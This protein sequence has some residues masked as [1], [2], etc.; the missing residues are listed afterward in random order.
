MDANETRIRFHAKQTAA[1]VRL[2]RDYG[3][4]RRNPAAAGRIGVL[5]GV[6][7]VDSSGRSGPSGLQWAGSWS[8]N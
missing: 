3:G 2:T 6:T 4:Q 7:E 8:T 5:G 1:V